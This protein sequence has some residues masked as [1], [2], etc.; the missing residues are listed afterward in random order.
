TARSARS[1]TSAPSSAS[2]S[3]ASAS[4][5]AR[6]S[7]GSAPTSGGRRPRT[8]RAATRAARQP[9]RCGPRPDRLASRRTEPL[10]KWRT[11]M[12]LGR[13]ISAVDS[14][15]ARSSRDARRTPT[16]GRVLVVDDERSLLRAY[17]RLLSGEGYE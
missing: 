7:S 15:P 9:R 17:E 5:S 2:P 14:Q 10:D 4:S 13:E 1:A 11:P 3:P 6:P 8:S 12:L 16:K